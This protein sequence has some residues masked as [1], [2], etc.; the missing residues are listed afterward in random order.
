MIRARRLT[1][2]LV[3]L[4]FVLVPITPG[5]SGTDGTGGGPQA[6]VTRGLVFSGEGNRLNVYDAESG[7]KQTVIPSV[8]D[9]PTVGR[10]INAQ[11]CFTEIDG[12]TY[13]IAG[14]DSGQN[15]P[16]GRPGW[17]W[18]ELVGNEVG[19]LDWRQH[20]KLAPTWSPAGEEDAENY[21]CGFLDD[22]RLVTS[23]VGRQLPHEE[24]SGQLIV[25][26]PG[27]DGG[28]ADAT[29][30]TPGQ[31]HDRVDNSLDDGY[32]KVDTELGT[33]GGVWVDD[34][35]VYVATNRPGPDGP[36]GVYRYPID[37]LPDD[38][39]CFGHGNQ[40]DLV[41]E[42]E[43]D[44]ELWL[45]SDSFVLTPSAL[46]P[47]GRT[48]LGHPTWYVSSVFTGVIAEY[49]DLGHARVHLRNLVEPP[50]GA[51][52]GQLDDLP[53]NDAGTPFGMG[54]DHNGALWYADLGIQGPGP[55]GG[56][57][58]VQRVLV[59]S[60]GKAAHRMIA[61]EGLDFPDGIGILEVD[62]V[63]PAAEGSFPV[64]GVPGNQSATSDSSC[65]DWRM[66]GR[67]PART[68][69]TPEECSGI[70]ALN[71]AVLAPKW[72][73]KT[74][75]TVTASPVVADGT[76]FVGDWSGTMYAVDAESG[77][78]RWT[79]ETADAPGASFGPI[80]SSAA[81]ADV[82]LERSGPPTTLVV[83]GS[84]PR[85]YALD[86]ATG[87]AA[88]VEDFS[89]LDPLTGRADPDT[90]VEIESSP[91]VWRGAVYVGID[92]HNTPGTG[93][94]G[95]LL[96]LDA[97]TGDEL[98]KF[99]PE[100]DHGDHGCGGVWSSPTL[101][102]EHRLV[103]VAT[104]NCPDRNDEFEWTPHTEAVTAL[105]AGT[106]EV[107][108]SFQPHLPNRNDWDFGATPN[109]FELEDG[110][111]VLG[112]GNKDG[113]YYT[114][115]GRTGELLWATKVAEPGDAGENFSI[116]GYLGSTAA[117]DGRVFGGTAIGGPPYYHALDAGS[118]AVEWRGAQAPSYATSAGVNDVV[119][120][121]ALDDVFR[122]YHADTGA[123]LWAAPLLGPISSGPAVVGDSVYVG[124]G[125]SSSDACR[126]E[127]GDEI[128]NACIEAFDEAVGATGGIHAFE[129]AL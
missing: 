90:P 127:L 60:N 70:G 34:S 23:D 56:H 85:L 115:D 74:E 6:T 123:V 19:D 30:P 84:G 62:G 66:Y 111:S 22:G 40:A 64:T 96:A 46:V 86:T 112:I 58:S 54:L 49:A 51:P 48:F 119:F 109:L 107:V 114:L 101:D 55:A 108:W 31:W 29:D 68:F 87:E 39:T 73:V 89:S 80:V 116:G 120:S 63:T 117:H 42:G 93:V 126:K 128:N 3:P 13:F 17:G 78:T 81:I 102:T 75:K 69:S 25:W 4:L 36:G 38:D 33:G 5:A 67:S 88:W 124:S 53:L 122:A 35:H 37:R 32:C 14:E 100:L 97:A 72:V 52:I 118:G 26:F 57:G 103:Y 27:D 98:W 8:Q 94:R 79:F 15:D 95:G 45:P 21:G 76:V 28:F 99:E 104:A 59:D 125:T 121:G 82:K 61:D 20:G 105:D 41:N 129:L 2:F 12:T 91:V 18:F 113:A 10:D 43:V 50:G 44:K 71:A 7:E 24:A 16:R 110:T 65:D 47:S 83:F 92:N 106:G 1:A 9:D 77:D 11:I